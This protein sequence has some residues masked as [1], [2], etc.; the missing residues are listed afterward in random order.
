MVRKKQTG[1]RKNMSAVETATIN[2]TMIDSHRLTKVHPCIH[3][4]DAKT[5]YNRIIRSHTIFNSR[6]SGIFDNI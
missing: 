1:G 5:C 4:D 2:E 6:K 3:Q